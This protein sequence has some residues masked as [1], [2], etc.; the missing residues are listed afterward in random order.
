MY[1]KYPKVT[2]QFLKDLIR[3][4]WNIK[5]LLDHPPP[6]QEAEKKKKE[7]FFLEKGFTDQIRK[8]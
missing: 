2:G 4:A 5:E 7:L 6:E 8:Q 3:L 1:Q